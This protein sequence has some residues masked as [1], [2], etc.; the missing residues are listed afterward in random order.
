MDDPRDRFRIVERTRPSAYQLE[1]ARPPLRGVFWFDVD[2]MQGT[3]TAT[4]GSAAGFVHLAIYLHRGPATDGN[5]P[6]K[7]D[8]EVRETWTQ[9]VTSEAPQRD[10]QVAALVAKIFELARIPGQRTVRVS[11]AAR[12]A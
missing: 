4:E 11:A 8:A 9:Q 10:A 12:T 7:I 6:P 5:P 3:L 1:L 2:G